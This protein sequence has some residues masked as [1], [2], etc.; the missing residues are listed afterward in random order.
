MILSDAP[1]TEREL[2]QRALSL[3]SERLTNGWSVEEVDN[4]DLKE[5]DAVI[6][7]SDQGGQSATIVIEAKRSPKGRDVGRVAERL[8]ANASRFPGSY[9]L[10]AAQYLSPPVREKLT[11]EGVSYI[12]ATGNIRVAIDGPA[13]FVSDKGSDKD[14][15]RGA[16]RPLGTLKGAPAAKI[17]RAIAD[18][19]QTWAMRQLVE[20]SKTSTGS[21]YR[22][23][24]YLNGEGLATRDENGSVRVPDWAQVLRRWSLSYS[25]MGSNSTSSWLAPR[26]LPA[27]IERMASTNVSNYAVTGTIAAAEWSAYAP[28]RLATAY[29]TNAESAAEAWGLRP[30]ESG[31]N[32]ILATP[33]FDV[34]FE[35]SVTSGDG[36]TLAAPT[37][38]AV[39][40]MTGPGRNPGEAEEL[41]E[42]MERNE[43]TWR[44]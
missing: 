34:V 11:Q 8:K 37:Q 10:V 6:R 42:W 25:F 17:V 36:L 38:V 13:L 19:D 30:V 32:V 4:S 35:R 41:L 23:I 43:R 15:W 29:I 31:A 9:F 33:K 7:I 14:P 39:D 22:V 21:A 44:N 1:K 12:D 40:L 28:A 2:I 26:G 24:E 5:L 16:G 3:L 27:L 20:A 18:I